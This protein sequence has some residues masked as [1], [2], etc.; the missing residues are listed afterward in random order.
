MYAV[1]GI[2]APIAVMPL[3]PEA[4]G[5]GLKWLF[6][7]FLHHGRRRCLRLHHR[8]RPTPHERQS[9][10]WGLVTERTTSS[11]DAAQRAPRTPKSFCMYPPVP[12][13]RYDRGPEGVMTT[14]APALDPD[15][16]AVAALITN[17]SLCDE[18]VSKRIGLPAR[19]VPGVV[20]QIA[21]TLVVT[22][23]MGRCDDCLRQTVVH[24]LV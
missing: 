11:A 8:L 9:A 20:N 1:V 18:C 10:R 21:E 14:P 22:T 23:R 16:M 15:A 13:Q 7:A 17:V 12:N 19:R 2:V 3:S 4:F 24:R 5:P 6:M